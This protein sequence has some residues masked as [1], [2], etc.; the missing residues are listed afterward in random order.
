MKIAIAHFGSFPV[1]IFGHYRL[2]LGLV[3]VQN[4]GSYPS[5]GY[6]PTLGVKRDCRLGMLLANPSSISTSE[7]PAPVANRS[8]LMMF[9]GS[10]AIL[11]RWIRPVRVLQVTVNVLVEVSVKTTRVTVY[12][13]QLNRIKQ[14]K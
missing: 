12:V 11:W 5:L 10:L 8:W 6:C 9:L 1:H 3:P 7:L 14:V 4:F 13:S 2:I